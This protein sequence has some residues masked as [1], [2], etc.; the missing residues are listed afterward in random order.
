M[1]LNFVILINVPR[2]PESLF[3]LP[4]LGLTTQMQKIGDTEGTHLTNTKSNWPFEC[5]YFRHRHILEADV[6]NQDKY[7]NMIEE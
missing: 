4:L 7:L 2:D 3:F 5:Q 6:L 1:F